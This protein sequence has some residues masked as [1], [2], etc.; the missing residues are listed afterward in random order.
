M[1]LSDELMQ[2][3]RELASARGDAYRRHLAPEAVVVV[4]GAVLDREQCAAAI[5]RTPRWEEWNISE[6][7]AI[8]LGADCA[9]LTYRWRS[10]RGTIHYAAVMSSVYARREGTWRLVL[11]QQTPGPELTS[12]HD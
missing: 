7:R 10:K 5:D 8:P 4:P 11:H 6:E 9:L 2:I 12:L 1:P 3:E